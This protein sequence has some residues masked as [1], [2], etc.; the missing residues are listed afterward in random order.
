MPKHA[1]G[2]QMLTNI[3]VRLEEA[4]TLTASMPI[5]FVEGLEK[6]REKDRRK[7]GVL[8]AAARDELAGRELALRVVSARR[9]GAR[10]GEEGFLLKGCALRAGT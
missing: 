8:C 1:R 2:P 7:V 3:E 6:T 4:L 5:D 10:W 9:T